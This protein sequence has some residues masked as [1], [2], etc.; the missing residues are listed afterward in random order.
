MFDK[1]YLNSL[2]N[3]L[4]FCTLYSYLPCYATINIIKV[5]TKGV[6]IVSD[7]TWERIEIEHH[8]A[9]IDGKK[10]PDKVIINAKT[11]D[12]FFFIFILPIFVMFE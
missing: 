5:L 3:Y 9:I 12:T 8:I 7:S 10:A 11:I 4:N 2:S 1:T 6:T